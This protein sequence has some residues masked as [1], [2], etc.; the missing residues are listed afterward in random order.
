[1]AFRRLF[2]IVLSREA[3]Y[4]RSLTYQADRP[5]ARN[6]TKEAWRLEQQNSPKAAAYLRKWTEATVTFAKLTLEGQVVLWT[7][8]VVE[9][10]I[11]KIS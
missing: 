1:M 5:N 6:P 9:R 3:T 11:G 7:S 10:A 2:P 4:K 8:N